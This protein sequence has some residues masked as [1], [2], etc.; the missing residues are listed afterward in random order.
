MRACVPPPTHRPNV[1]RTRAAVARWRKRARCSRTIERG[2]R[3]GE[4]EDDYD[5]EAECLDCTGLSVSVGFAR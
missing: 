1:Q 3:D 5:D 2:K 4:D